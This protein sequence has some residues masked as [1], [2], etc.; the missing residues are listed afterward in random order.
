MLDN[1][2]VKTVTVGTNPQYVCWD[3]SRYMCTAN[4]GGNSM[5]RISIAT[6]TVHDTITFASGAQSDSCYWDGNS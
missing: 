2:V 3:G 5:T 1:T 4:R 6:Q